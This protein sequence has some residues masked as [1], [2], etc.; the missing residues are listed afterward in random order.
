[1]GCTPVGSGHTARPSTT[2]PSIIFMHSRRSS[3]ACS[4]AELCQ[5]PMGR[6]CHDAGQLLLLLH[7]DAMRGAKITRTQPYTNSL[8]RTHTRARTHTHT[9]RT[10]YPEDK[11]EH[12][13][14]VV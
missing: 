14:G 5:P 7:E 9:H 8:T 3:L 2:M 1:M 4:M 6:N 13:A 12:L 11:D 10:R